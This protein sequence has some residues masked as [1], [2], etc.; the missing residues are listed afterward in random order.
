M[1]I[2]DKIVNSFFEVNFTCKWLSVNVLIYN[3]YNSELLLI[4]SS[5]LLI[6]PEINILLFLSFLFNRSNN[7]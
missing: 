1:R 6:I 4:Y 7:K 2:I 5:N 3:S